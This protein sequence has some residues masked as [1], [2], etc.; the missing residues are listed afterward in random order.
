MA[1]S[2]GTVVALVGDESPDLISELG[3][4]RNVEAF[5]MADGDE[6]EVAHRIIHSH[7]SFVVCDADPLAHVATAWVEFFDDQVTLETLLIEAQATAEALRSGR[8]L[9]PDYY[10]VLDP[11]TVEGTWRHWWF[12]A[13]AA[14]APTRVLPVQPSSG[15]VRRQ[16]RHLPTGRP[17][18]AGFAEWLTRLQFEVP[19]RFVAG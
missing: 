5:T 16:L 1:A 8:A 13:L 17:W 19:D 15:E 4:L 6:A 3:A 11:E 12:G 14:K 10:L 7:A 18:P 9:L 2:N